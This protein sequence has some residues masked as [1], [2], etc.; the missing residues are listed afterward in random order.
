MTDK[1]HIEDVINRTFNV[2]KEVYKSQKEGKDNPIEKSDSRIIFPRKRGKDDEKD[3]KDEKEEVVTRVSE[4]ELRFIFVEQLNQYLQSSEGKDWDVCYSV[5]TPTIKKYYFK[6][7]PP[8]CDVKNGQSANFDL[9]IHQ[10][11]NLSRIALI[12]F[13]ANNPDIHDYQKDFVK[14]TNEE[15]EGEYRYFIQLLE[16]TRNGKDYTTDTRLNILEKIFPSKTETKWTDEWGKHKVIVH[17]VS[18]EKGKGEKSII[19]F[20]EYP[21]NS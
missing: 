5:E 2:V 12:E 7:D 21:N 17:C 8:R 20:T 9:V 16:N 18:L 3:E 11:T 10:R 14:L 1:E 15:E 13:K 6:E 4:Q 19:N